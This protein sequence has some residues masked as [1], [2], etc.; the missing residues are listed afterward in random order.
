MTAGVNCPSVQ[1]GVA[2]TY[3]PP[4]A[5]F[6]CRVADVGGGDDGGSVL[7]CKSIATA[8]QLLV[9]RVAVVASGADGGSI[10]HNAGAGS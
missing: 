7:L 2:I 10:L 5:L 4:V 8:P 1:D 9:C 6:V 3:L